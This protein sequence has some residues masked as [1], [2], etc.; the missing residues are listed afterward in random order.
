MSLAMGKPKNSQNFGNTKNRKH[1]TMV[2]MPTFCGEECWG[3]VFVFWFLLFGFLEVF[4]MI[5]VNSI[6][7]DDSGNEF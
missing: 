6:L 2:A 5:L 1:K 7:L 3:I 4:D